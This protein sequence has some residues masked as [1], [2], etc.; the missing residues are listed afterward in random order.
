MLNIFVVNLVI[1]FAL[2]WTLPDRLTYDIFLNRTY[3][4]FERTAPDS[5]Y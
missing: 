4:D 5:K 2:V 1:N 3:S